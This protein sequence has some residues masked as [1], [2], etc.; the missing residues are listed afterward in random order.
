MYIEDVE[1][2]LKDYN[3]YL[4]DLINQE[5]DF[6]KFVETFLKD[7]V[8]ESI[9]DITFNLNEF[10][11]DITN[12]KYCLTHLKNKLN[13]IN[14]IYESLDYYLDTAEEEYEREESLIFDYEVELVD[15]YYNDLAEYLADEIDNAKEDAEY[16]NNHGIEAYCRT[17]RN[18]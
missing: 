8:E 6:N 17:G 12:N 1:F 7:L 3:D 16:I 9:N 11:K 10:K 14:R 15:Y 5:G 2:D 18:D 4:F 13:Y